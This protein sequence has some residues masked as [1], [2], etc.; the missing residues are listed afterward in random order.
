MMPGTSWKKKMWSSCKCS[1]LWVCLYSS[2]RTCIA[3]DSM[4]STLR[5][6]TTTVMASLTLGWDRSLSLITTTSIKAT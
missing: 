6:L 4:Q 2:C 5:T 3:V 1:I